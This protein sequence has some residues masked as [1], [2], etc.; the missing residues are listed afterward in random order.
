MLKNLSVRFG[1]LLCAALIVLPVNTSVKQLSSNRSAAVSVAAL[2]GSPLPIPDPPGFS[3]LSATGSPLPIPDPPGF[4][5]LSP[6][7]SPLPIPDPPGLL[8]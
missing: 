4:S 2:T 1:L 7:G 6:T 5:A 8:A 3:V